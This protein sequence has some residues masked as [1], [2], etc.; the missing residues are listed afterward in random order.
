VMSTDDERSIGLDDLISAAKCET[1]IDQSVIRL[2][3]AI[4]S[5]LDAAGNDPRKLLELRSIIDNNKAEIAIAIT[6]SEGP[7]ALRTGWIRHG[8]AARS[9]ESQPWRR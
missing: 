8:P 7:R 2:I 3:E 6:A 9:L 4:S 5:H 1:E